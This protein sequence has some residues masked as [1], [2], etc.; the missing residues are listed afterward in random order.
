MDDNFFKK[1]IEDIKKVRLLSTEKVHILS[2]LKSRIDLDLKKAHYPIKYSW[3]EF[4]HYR[5]LSYSLVVLA[6]V[7]I[8]GFSAYSGIKNSLPGDNLYSLKVDVFEPIKLNMAVGDV[9]KANVST[10]NFSD[11]LLEAEILANQGRLSDS[12]GQEIENRLT[13]HAENISTF[14]GA[15]PDSSNLGLSDAKVDLEAIINSHD[16]ILTRIEEKSKNKSSNNSISKI[17][18]VINKQSSK[19]SESSQSQDMFSQ[20]MIIQTIEISTSTQSEG[21]INFNKRKKDTEKVIESVKKNIEKAR[22]GKTKVNRQIFEDSSKSLLEAE[23]SLLRAEESK[24]S[25]DKKRAVEDL[26]D[27]RKRAKEADNTFKASR[28]I[29]DEEDNQ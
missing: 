12:F 27:S 19:V 9:A 1:G 6:I 13:K 24:K 28:Y 29:E 17:K 8:S 11:R 5:S 21:D 20:T 26:I 14:L 4:S 18:N 15:N 22:K 16:R 25:G 7:M 10:E 2:N 3:Y 23:S